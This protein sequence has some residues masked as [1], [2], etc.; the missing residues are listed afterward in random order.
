MLSPAAEA[1]SY[2]KL[3]CRSPHAN[4]NPLSLFFF[5]SFF[6]LPPPLS[7]VCCVRPTSRFFYLARWVL[8]TLSRAAPSLRIKRGGLVGGVLVVAFC[9]V[10]TNPP[11]QGKKK[12]KERKRKKGKYHKTTEHKSTFQRSGEWSEQDDVIDAYD[13][14]IH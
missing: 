6:S 8:Q 9:S 7:F 13:I 12:K 10:L 2:V 5:F 11:K 3:H 14:E 4:T 1:R